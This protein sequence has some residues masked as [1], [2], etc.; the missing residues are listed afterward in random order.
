MNNIIKVL[1]VCTG[2]ICR[3]PTAEAVFRTLVKQKG[4]EANII[5][6]SAGVAGYHEGEPPD[7]RAVNFARSRKI[8]MSNIF[9]RKINKDD[10]KNFDIII[11]M[12][13]T[14]Q[15]TIYGLRPKTEEHQ[16]AKLNLLLDFVKDV[17][18]KDIPDPYYGGIEGFAKVF[19]LINLGS[20]Q[21]LNHI[22]SEYLK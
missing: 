5:A 13:H 1:F 11:S 2:N 6:D 17:K 10:F 9:A 21:L 14:H 12:E 4:L 15:H 8:D 19:D 16:R 20:E 18:N 22:C 3:S 7:S